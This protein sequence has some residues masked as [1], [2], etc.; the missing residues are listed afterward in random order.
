MKHE[1]RVNMKLVANYNL[2]RV[3]LKTHSFRRTVAQ[4]VEQVGQ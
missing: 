4:E 3:G 2:K 1:L